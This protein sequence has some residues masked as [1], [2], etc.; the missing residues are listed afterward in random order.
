MVTSY[1]T[2]SRADAYVY[3]AGLRRYMLGI[4]NHMALGLVTSGLIA[5][6]IRFSPSLAETLVFSPM[7]WLFVLA[8]FGIL[9]AMSWRFQ[10][11]SKSTLVTLYYVMT[12]SLGVALTVLLFAYTLESVAQTFFVTAASFAGLSLFGYTTKRSLS[13]LGTFCAMGLI[14]LVLAMVVNL[15]VGSSMLIFLISVG[16]VV[17][18]AGLTAYDTKRLKDQYFELSQHAGGDSELVG[19]VSIMGSVSLYLN[20]INLFQFLLLLMGSR[21]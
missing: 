13:G 8:P 4:Y 11:M 2:P 20:F 9:M 19:K 17:I 10:A 7:R 6:L 16:G 1:K 12:A 15:F 21:D 3:D 18:F 14:G 5:L